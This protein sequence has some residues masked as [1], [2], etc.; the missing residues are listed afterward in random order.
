MIYCTLSLLTCPISICSFLYTCLSNY[1]VLHR[2][3]PTRTVVNSQGYHYPTRFPEPLTDVLYVNFCSISWLLLRLLLSN[4]AS[5]L[6]GHT[7]ISLLKPGCQQQPTQPLLCFGLLS[8]SSVSRQMQLL[9]LR[10]LVLIFPNLTLQNSPHSG[11][12]VA[13]FPQTKYSC[14]VYRSPNPS[15]ILT[16]NLNILSHSPFY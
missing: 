1:T 9:W 16:Q 12:S 11:F 10:T 6:L 15:T 2:I 3:T 8:V 14:A 4:R 7:F 5:F 13:I